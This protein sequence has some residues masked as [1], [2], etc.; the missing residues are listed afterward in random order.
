MDRGAWRVAVHRVAKTRLKRLGTH[1]TGRGR[2]GASPGPW[3]PL[4]DQGALTVRL[5]EADGTSDRWLLAV[6][7][8]ASSC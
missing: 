4:G 6:S 5:G 1:A 7:P 2:A 8:A 3:S